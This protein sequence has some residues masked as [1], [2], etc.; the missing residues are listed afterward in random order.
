MAQYVFKKYRWNEWKPIPCM[1][2][3]YPRCWN[4]FIF[5]SPHSFDCWFCRIVLPF[6]PFDVHYPPSSY[7]CYPLMCGVCFQPFLQFLLWRN[8][9]S[10]VHCIPR[11]FSGR[12][13]ILIVQHSKRVFVNVLEW[14]L[15][16]LW[17]MLRETNSYGLHICST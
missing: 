8:L 6:S 15:K 17:N 16:V 4:H 2:H 9:V 5:H 7:L 11:E 14:S 1:L 13:T 12:S 3:C 10:D